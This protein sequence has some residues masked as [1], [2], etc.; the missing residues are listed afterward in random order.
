[1]PREGVQ[2]NIRWFRKGRGHARLKDGGSTLLFDAIFDAV[3][4]LDKVKHPVFVST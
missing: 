1:V 2:N 4:M 3:I